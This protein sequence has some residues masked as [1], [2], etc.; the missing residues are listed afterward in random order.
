MIQKVGQDFSKSIKLNLL[1][2]I[3]VPTGY[4]RIRIDWI[5]ND[6][7][8]ITQYNSTEF[9]GG[10]DTLDI[11]VGRDVHSITFWVHRHNS[12][13]ANP[14]VNYHTTIRIDHLLLLNLACKL[15]NFPRV[16][17]RYQFLNTKKQ[18]LARA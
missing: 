6:P 14:P 10:N 3:K 17:P 16:G 4:L 11:I 15:I 8:Q 7:H 9:N 18:A 5:T 13:P 2:H 1:P 12:Y